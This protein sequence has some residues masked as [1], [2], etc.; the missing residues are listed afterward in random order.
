M[1]TVSPSAELD[2]NGNVI[3]DEYALDGTGASTSAVAIHA[4]AANEL[5]IRTNSS[6]QVRIDSSGD[7]ILSGLTSAS[8]GTKAKI[9]HTSGTAANGE[10]SKNDGGLI[11]QSSDN[12]TYVNGL[13]IDHSGKVGI[14]T[15]SPAAPLEV[16]STG[17]GVIIPRMTT[18][19][20][21]AISSPSD[22]MMIYN[23]TTNKF[24]GRANNAWVDFH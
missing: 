23:T 11:L 6:E 17:G 15:I 16:S 7:I 5:A 20:R 13:T 8:Q 19:Q 22:G 1:G 2:V 18:T 21:D 3:A 14:G 9:V 12:G 24:Q 4:P 10:D